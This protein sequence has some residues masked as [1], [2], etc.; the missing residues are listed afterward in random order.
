[1]ERKLKVAHFGAFDHDSYGDLIMP[2]II[3]HFCPD[4]EFIHVAKSN[5]KTPWP[6]AKKIISV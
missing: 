3:E 1:M 4:V 5:E 2:Y 6:D